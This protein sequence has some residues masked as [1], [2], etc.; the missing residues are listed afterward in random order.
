MKTRFFAD[1]DPNREENK[2]FV[3]DL[4][5]L[6]RLS[7]ENRGHFYKAI[8]DSTRTFDP[9][10]DEEILQRLTQDTKQVRPHVDCAFRA[11]RFLAKQLTRDE[12]QMDSPDDLAEDLRDLAVIQA[13]EAKAVAQV[14]AHAKS[15][16]F[17]EYSKIALARAYSGGVLPSLRSIGTTVELRPVIEPY[18]RL[19]MRPEEYKPKIVDQVPVISVHLTVDSGPAKEFVFQTSPDELEAIV[20]R[21]QGTLMDLHLLE[22]RFPA[23]EDKKKAKKRRKVPKRTR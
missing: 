12:F 8:L 13:D 7:P 23:P 5:D 19:G 17:P 20:R 9:M 10:Q 2:V 21:L 22:K 1:F 6:L 14:I 11:L 15:E 4:R 16:L 3:R 18:F